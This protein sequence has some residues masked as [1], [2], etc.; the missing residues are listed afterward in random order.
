[1]KIELSLPKIANTLAPAVMR[2]AMDR[3]AEDT[4]EKVREY[5]RKLPEDWF[6]SPETSFPDGTPKH[7]RG[8]TFMRALSTHWQTAGVSAS[9]FSL[10]FRATRDNGSPWG[11]RLQEYGGT[12]RPKNA[13]AL[14]IPLTAEARGRRASEYSA[15]VHPLFAVGTKKSGG[16]GG[17]L[18]WKDD[19]GQLHAAYA[20]RKSVEIAPLIKRRHHHGIP[21]EHQLRRMAAPA[22]LEA[23]KDLQKKNNK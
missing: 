19:A 6:D 9:G 5:Y 11:L 16:K 1:M 8:R 18:V 13:R 4:A 2:E 10:V 22:L 3:A 12:I 20:L 21:T 7:G 23:I 15:G 14:T 17:T